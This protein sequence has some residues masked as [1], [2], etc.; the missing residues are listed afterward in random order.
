MK[1]GEILKGLKMQSAEFLWIS[2]LF[3][4]GQ[5]FSRFEAKNTDA[6]E[7]RLWRDMKIWRE[8]FRIPVGRA[9]W[10]SS[11]NL[12][13]LDSGPTFSLSACVSDTQVTKERSWFPE[14]LNSSSWIHASFLWFAAKVF[15]IRWLLDDYI[16][17]INRSLL[18]W[19]FL[20]L[21]A[22]HVD[23]DSSDLET[24][25]ENSHH[26]VRFEWKRSEA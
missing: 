7:Q 11:W 2:S 25:T 23:G 14:L 8:E 24:N 16:L 13:N 21:G 18:K 9:S 1:V 15:G 12:Q 4:I 5:L 10:F 22:K 17:D 6:N 3:K 26:W 19:V 20:F